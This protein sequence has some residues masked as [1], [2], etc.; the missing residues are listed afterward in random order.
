MSR[1]FSHRHHIRCFLELESLLVGESGLGVYD[2]IRI[3][4][5]F[6]FLTLDGRRVANSR[7]T[8]VRSAANAAESPGRVHCLWNAACSTLQVK[9]RGARRQHGCGDDDTGN[10]HELVHC[11]CGE[12]AELQHVESRSDGDLD[13]GYQL[14]GRIRALASR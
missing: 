13:L 9:F 8:P 2:N 4:W 5:T 6:L 10:S 12:V 11:V 14:R 3:Q 1:Q 7:Q